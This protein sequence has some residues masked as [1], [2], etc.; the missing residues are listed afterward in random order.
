MACRRTRRFST[1]TRV[2]CQKILRPARLSS[3]QLLADGRQPSLKTQAVDAALTHLQAKA[4]PSQAQ[5]ARIVAFENQVYAAQSHDKVAGA[6]TG[7][8]APP[9]LGPEPCATE[10]PRGWATIRST[11]CWQ[12]RHVAEAASPA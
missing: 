9:G 12:F 11:R 1:T 4:K 3:L 5:L 8:G 10:L 2:C 6:L 7:P